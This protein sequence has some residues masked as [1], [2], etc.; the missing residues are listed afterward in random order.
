MLVLF[1]FFKKFE[2]LKYQIGTNCIRKLFSVIVNRIIIINTGSCLD[3]SEVYIHWWGVCLGWSLCG[4][5]IL[6]LCCP[7][8]KVE[9]I[10]NFVLL[11]LFDHFFEHFFP[12]GWLF[13]I[14]FTWF[15]IDLQKNC[16]IN[17]KNYVKNFLSFTYQRRH[18][19]PPYL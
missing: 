2:C 8:N 3:V 18:S 19:I 9:L 7:L 12:V 13:F 4:V 14:I 6:G 1:F 16:L 15:N 10:G 11:F 5:I 17:I